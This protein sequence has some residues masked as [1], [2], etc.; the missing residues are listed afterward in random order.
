MRRLRSRY[1]DELRKK[2][3]KSLALQLV[4]FGALFI[5]IF[6]G[7]GYLAQ[8]ASLNVKTVTILGNIAVEESEVENLVREELSGKYLWLYPKTNF[9]LYPKHKIKTRL[10]SEFKTFRDIDIEIKEDQTMEVRVSEREGKYLWCQ[11]SG[12]PCYFMDETGYVFA[13]APY[14]S[15]NIYFKFFG[16]IDDGPL[17]SYY[18]ESNFKKLTEFREEIAKLAL[19]PS[20]MY[21][22]SENFELRT[23]LGIKIYLKED[24]N[25]TKSAENLRLI[26]GSD[27]LKKRSADLDY[28][29]LRYGNKVYYKLK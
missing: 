12:E 24:F 9:L 3:R 26:L 7:I 8:A 14:F 23:S 4:I 27:E 18:A 16:L 19:N 11:S 5:G 10:A 1:A 22:D 6:V 13:E 20:A 28:I 21:A 17:G 25:S 29:D 2:K 15:G